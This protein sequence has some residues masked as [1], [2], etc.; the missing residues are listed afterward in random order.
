MYSAV[1]AGSGWLK[2]GGSYVTLV[3]PAT[4]ETASAG[5]T[6]TMVIE[7]MDPAT[8]H[9]EWEGVGNSTTPLNETV[10]FTLQGALAKVTK[11]NVWRSLI[12]GYA[13]SQV[14]EKLDPI[15]VSGGRFSIDLCAECIFSVTTLSIGQKGTFSAVPRLTG[16]VD[17]TSPAGFSDNF[18]HY[19]LSSEAAYWSDMSGSWEIVAA[20]EREIETKHEAHYMREHV[21]PAPAAAHGKVMRQMVPTPPIF[22]IR[23]EVRPLSMIGEKTWGDTNLS[24]D[25]LVT[26]PSGTQF[27]IQNAHIAP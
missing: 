26:T 21:E 10:S 5:P 12:G 25:V 4:A 20:T 27:A 15:A 7:K 11:L 3:P 23:T 16:W 17:A 6:M 14:F 22:G 19:N 9:C 2:Q 24:I 18:D 1:G 8:S 13:S